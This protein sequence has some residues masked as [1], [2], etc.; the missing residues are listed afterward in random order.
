M[1]K[2][3]Y[4]FNKPVLESHNLTL[5]EQVYDILREEIYSGRWEIGERLPSISVLAEESGLSGWPFQKAFELLREEG[6]IVQKSG[7]GSYLA[8]ILPKGRSL[9]GAIGV[10]ILLEEI[11]RLRTAHVRLHH[12]LDAATKRNY[13]TEPVYLKP[14]DDWESINTKNAYFSEQVK[15]VISLK[16]F[17][18][19]PALELHHDKLPMV[20]ISGYTCDDYC[21]PR[22]CGDMVAGYYH[23]TQKVIQAGH[24]NIILCYDP[25][26]SKEEAS[27]NIK[28]H[29]MAMK[30]ADLIFNRDAYE[31]SQL[32]PEGDLSFMSAFLDEFSDATAVITLAGDMALNV[33]AIADMK[34]ISVPEDLSV[35]CHGPGPMRLRTPNE[36][37]TRCDF[38][39][40]AISEWAFDILFKQME[41]RINP[42]NHLIV[43]P[44]II[45]GE[46]LAP[47]SYKTHVM[48]QDEPGKN[49]KVHLEN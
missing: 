33:V 32:I 16:S 3:Q 34:K 26:F 23:L 8:S 39:H 10:A 42:I 22:I 48:V 46:S 18:S 29:E 14:D 2:K 49:I 17:P 9:S 7:S 27:F 47:P 45:D 37:F 20:F 44:Q 15:G 41:T 11:P 30:E 25:R 40:K 21:M 13:I 38:D 4:L 1:A 36:L 43:P 28:G 19:M 6:Y 31:Y 5:T 24:Q 12:I 35:V